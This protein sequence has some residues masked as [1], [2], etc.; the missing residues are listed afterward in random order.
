[1]ELVACVYITWLN[2]LWSKTL[3]L[4]FRLC[5]IVDLA[6]R[7]GCSKVLMSVWWHWHFCNRLSTR[8]CASMVTMLTLLVLF[9][10]QLPCSWGLTVLTISLSQQIWFSFPSN[11]PLYSPCLIVDPTAVWWSSK[12]VLSHTH[13]LPAS[14]V[15]PS[16][17]LLSLCL[18]G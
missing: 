11:F 12:C 16:P 7:N 8:T 14:S 10:L 17:S 18:G 3:L 5:Q 4:P 6:V 9:V 15:P 13:C 2:H 1:M